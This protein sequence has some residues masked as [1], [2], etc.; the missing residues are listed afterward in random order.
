MDDKQKEIAAII[1]AATLVELVKHTIDKVG[2][3][4]MAPVTDSVR[5][6][7]ISKVVNQVWSN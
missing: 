2:L 3:E 6:E 5:N 1:I 4:H 7:Q